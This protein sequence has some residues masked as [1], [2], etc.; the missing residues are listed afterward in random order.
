MS[1]GD[2]RHLVS[3]RRVARELDAVVARRGK[4]GLIVS[5][6][7]TEFTAN[8]TLAWT[9]SNEIRPALHRAGQADAE[10]DLRSVQR[11]DPRRILNET[12]FL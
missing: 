10:Q 8:A 12:I 6:H 2:R 11:P 1:R 3:R 7:G 4:P 5:D 9:Q